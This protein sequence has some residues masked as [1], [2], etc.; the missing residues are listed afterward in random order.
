LVKIRRFRGGFFL[1]KTSIKF[2]A[3]VNAAK[4]VC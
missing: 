3:T 4:F 2:C 1:P